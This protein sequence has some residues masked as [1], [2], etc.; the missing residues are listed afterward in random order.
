MSDDLPFP[1][2]APVEPVKKTPK[3]VKPLELVEDQKELIR[4]IWD[5]KDLLVVIGETFGGDPT[6]TLDSPEG[7]AVRLFIST[8]DTVAPIVE[9][10][11]EEVRLKQTKLT[12]EQIDNITVLLENESPPTVKEIV[13]LL[14]GE[15]KDLSPLHTEYRM[16]Y[17][18]VK[19]INEEATNIW[20]EPVTSR[21]YEPPKSLSAMIG[22]TN[23]YVGNPANPSKALYDPATIKKSH[24]NNLNALVSYMK[25]VKFFQQASQYDR[26]ADR[27]L[28]ESTFVRHVQDKAS[29]LSPEEVDTYINIATETVKVAR[30]DRDILYQERIRDNIFEAH[31]T[32]E[33]SQKL[34]MPLVE[35]IKTLIGNRD[36]SNKHL[37]K[38]IESVS[39]ARSERLKLNN[40]RNDALINIISKW[41]EEKGRNELIA[42][43]KKEHMEDVAE[44]DRIETLD[45]TWALMAGLTRKEALYGQQ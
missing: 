38:L 34:S 27:N 1:D 40:N 6:L 31:G 17:A 30:F 33:N 18:A 20:D 13:K 24:E 15:I 23:R 8:I 29:D 42:L 11:K 3:K 32:T 10:P 19:K 44:F 39:G 26:Q 2:D 45:D 36:G 5:K 43:A 14:F 22:M 7:K 12:Q 37:H 16:V 4:R 25:N 35:S 41:T 9:P 21:R 28:F